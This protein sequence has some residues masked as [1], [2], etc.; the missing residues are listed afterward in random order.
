MKISLIYNIKFFIFQLKKKVFNFPMKN[1][2][3]IL[4]PILFVWIVPKSKK[5]QQKKEEGG[6]IL[7]VMK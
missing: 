2:Q 5:I 7:E 4:I 1:Y 3:Q 6:G